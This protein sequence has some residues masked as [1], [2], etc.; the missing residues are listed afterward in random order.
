MRIARAH[1]VDFEGIRN[2][3]REIGR[4]GV[5][6]RHGAGHDVHRPAVHAGYRRV[7]AAVLVHPRDRSTATPEGEINVADRLRVSADHAPRLGMH[8]DFLTPQHDV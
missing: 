7:A 8:R 2:A 6:E 3:Q 1:T 4:L 5:L